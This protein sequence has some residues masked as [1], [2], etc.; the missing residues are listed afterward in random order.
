MIIR[1]LIHKLEEEKNELLK[2][3]SLLKK[4]NEELKK[5][6]K[7]LVDDFNSHIEVDADKVIE[8]VKPEEELKPKRR[9]RKESEDIIF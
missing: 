3:N 9:R 8:E 7:K 5:I 6:N 2:E 4:E 1:D